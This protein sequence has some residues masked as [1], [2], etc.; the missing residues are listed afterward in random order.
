MPVEDKREL[1]RR[2]QSSTM[3]LE[4]TFDKNSVE[5]RMADLIDNK[6]YFLKYQEQLLKL[7]SG[8]MDVAQFIKG[9]APDVAIQLTKLA[10]ASDNEKIRLEAARD[11]LDRSGY[12]KVDK[13]AVATVDPSVPKE[14]LI[15]MINGLGKK[16]KTVEIVDE[17]NEETT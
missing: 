11:L 16:T 3:G 5:D 14:Q 12:G 10:L 15:A 13:V 2:I 6:D 9:L 7:T 8:K 17:D 1:K 4:R